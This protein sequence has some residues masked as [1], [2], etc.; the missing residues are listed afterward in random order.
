[1]KFKDVIIP[2]VTAL[3][4]FFASMFVTQKTIDHQND[5]LNRE[6]QLKIFE[7]RMS[8]I[9][10]ASKLRGAEPNTNDIFNQ[11]VKSVI[12]NKSS[13]ILSLSKQLGE[14]N[15]RW[16]ANLALSSL[17]FGESTQFAIAQ[18]SNQSAP[19][20]NK[21]REFQDNYLNAMI[22]EL[23]LGINNSTAENY[24][25]QQFNYILAIIL[26]IGLIIYVTILYYWQRRKEEPLQ[27]IIG[28]MVGLWLA[29]GTLLYCAGDHTFI[30]DW[31]N[32]AVAIGTIGTVVT[33][34]Y[35]ANRT[36]DIHQILALNY[37]Y[38][39]VG[40]RAYQDEI[41]LF[42]EL[43][44]K[45]TIEFDIIKISFENYQ[46]PDEICDIE[47]NAHVNAYQVI[48]N[49]PALNIDVLDINADGE[50]TIQT[51]PMKANE[52]DR[53]KPKIKRAV[54]ITSIGRIPLTITF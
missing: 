8:I 49:S 38:I 19:W 29:V 13:T 44:N 37:C 2:I 17:Y 21:K 35:L 53:F 50:E 54:L 24:T 1:M 22:K 32:T 26:L 51:R 34:L 28:V 40:D 46:N 52:L 3:I 10:E 42:I 18:M 47:I 14:Y 27:P 25:S 20:W 43:R 48:N 33:S 6:Y 15:S 9:D 23:Y 36:F 12:N 45:T 41:S 11:Y 4:A 7:K 16:Q 31:I 5:T 30:A 39:D